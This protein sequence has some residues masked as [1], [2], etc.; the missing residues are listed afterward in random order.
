MKLDNVD[1]RVYVKRDDCKYV[2]TGGLGTSCTR[3]KEVKSVVYCA[4][5]GDGISTCPLFKSKV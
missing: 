3:W 4:C 1:T 5:M 2:R